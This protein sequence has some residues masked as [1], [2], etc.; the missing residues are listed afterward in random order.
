MAFSNYL[1][2][3]LCIS[4]KLEKL[5]VALPLVTLYHD[6]LNSKI[7]S[8]NFD[9]YIR[10]IFLQQDILIPSLLSRQVSYTY[11]FMSVHT[12]YQIDFYHF[13][14]VAWVGAAASTVSTL[15]LS[16]PY[17]HSHHYIRLNCTFFFQIESMIRSTTLSA[18]AVRHHSLRKL[19]HQ[20]R[21]KEVI[22]TVKVY[23]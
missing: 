7:V 2:G 15:H 8:Y 16:K 12:S 3:T 9:L 6:L 1:L 17:V 13:R 10:C 23:Y 18:V 21:A 11:T 22:V 20:S 14:A 19:C 5:F 4:N